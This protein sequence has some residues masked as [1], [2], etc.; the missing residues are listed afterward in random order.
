MEPYALVT[1][2]EA[3]TNNPTLLMIDLSRN[4]LDE[5]TITAILQRL[6]FN[7]CLQHLYLSG[8]PISSGVYYENVIKPYFRKRKELQVSID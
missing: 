5:D 7:P 6:Y 4:E 8:N 2:V 3:L 1:F